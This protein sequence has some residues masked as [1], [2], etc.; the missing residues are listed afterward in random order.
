MWT[1]RK[2]RLLSLIR[3]SSSSPTQTIPLPSNGFC[4]SPVR[5]QIGFS[6]LRRLNGRA[7]CESSARA[8]PAAQNEKLMKK[9]FELDALRP[10][11][12]FSNLQVVAR[13]SERSKGGSVELATDVAKVFPT[14]E[15]VN[16]ALRFLIRIGKA[17][18]R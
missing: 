6:W 2:L 13:G 12:D 4:C 14:A 8:Q 18:P 10:E 9:T 17:T 11:Y 15:A 5:G 1:S 7:M 3:S 16:E